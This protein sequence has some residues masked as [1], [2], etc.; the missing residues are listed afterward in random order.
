MWVGQPLPCPAAGDASE[1]PTYLAYE[2]AQ[3]LAVPAA[4][5]FGWL[6]AAGEP[7]RFDGQSVTTLASPVFGVPRHTPLAPSTLADR[8]GDDVPV[9]LAAFA[10]SELPGL[11]PTVT[12]CYLDLAHH[13]VDAPGGGRLLHLLADSQG[14]LH[15]L[16][17]LACDGTQAI[18]CTDAWFGYDLGA[19]TPALDPDDLPLLVIVAGSFTEFIWRF[20]LDNTVWLLA[21]AGL[22]LS[23]AEQRYVDSLVPQT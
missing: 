5:D 18:L 1:N 17:H 4:G 3:G 19:E 21:E 8:L 10:V 2:P 23:T 12:D 20:W 9:D 15:W 11:V 6:R 22:P 7:P 14:V 16:L 13:V